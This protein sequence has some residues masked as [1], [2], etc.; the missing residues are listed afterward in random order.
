[1][2]QNKLL[3]RIVILIAVVGAISFIGIRAPETVT[4]LVPEFLN[5]S[6]GESLGEQS[7][8]K[9]IVVGPKQ[10]AEL[11]E[12]V[13]VT[14]VDK[15]TI[16]DVLAILKD[17]GE[18][19]YYHFGLTEKDFLETI[20]INKICQPDHYYLSIFYPYPGTDLHKICNKNLFKYCSLILKN[21]KNSNCKK[22]QV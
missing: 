8:E 22:G 14:M 16:G 5:D 10:E 12:E 18:A 6:Q 4:S 15:S 1:M 11:A 7:A 9:S 20:R 17:V 21:D 13:S 3:V 19:A 2:A